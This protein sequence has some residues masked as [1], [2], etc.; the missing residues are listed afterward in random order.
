T[1]GIVVFDNVKVVKRH[2]GQMIVMNK[3]GEILIKT[4][5]GV[6]KE[7]YPAIY[8]ATLF[9]ANNE[10]INVGDK[11]LEWDPFAMAIIGEV[12]GTVKF[13]DLV[14]G[15]T[16]VEV[17]DSVTGLSHRVVIESKSREDLSKQP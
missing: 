16:Y 6:E 11:I 2:D 14:I 17:M 3:N 13:E 9:F 8:G 7:R 1:S 15:S 12:A 4:E 10:K 5:T